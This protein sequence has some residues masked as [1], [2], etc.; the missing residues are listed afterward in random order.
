MHTTPHFTAKCQLISTSQSEWNVEREREKNTHTTRMTTNMH[1][2]QM[3]IW[4]CKW[5]DVTGARVSGICYYCFFRCSIYKFSFRDKWICSSFSVLMTNPKWAALFC[6]NFCFCLF[7]CLNRE[8]QK[9]KH[10]NQHQITGF[11]Q[12]MP[13]KFDMG[14][15]QMKQL[16]VFV[17]SAQ[18]RQ[19]PHNRI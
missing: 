18:C 10:L 2:L 13:F 4:A 16:W 15:A 6:S 1:V 7:I 8:E 11:D 19:Q 3:T 9:G 5:F 14:A 12:S 17:S